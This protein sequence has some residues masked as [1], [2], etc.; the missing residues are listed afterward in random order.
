M[1]TLRTIASFLA[2]VALSLPAIAQDA[3]PEKHP[4][5]QFLAPAC[6]QIADQ[7]GNFPVQR[8]RLATQYY[9]PLFPPGR[10]GKL[11]PEDRKSCVN[12]EGACVVGDFLYDFNGTAIDRSTVPFKFGP[13]SGKGPFNTTNALDPCRTLAADGHV[14]PMGTVIFIPEMRNKICPQSGMPVDGCFIVA[15]VGSAITGGQR[16]DMFTGEC[17]QYDKRTSTCLDPAN[18]AFVAPKGTPFNVI[19][20]DDPLAAQLRK[21]TDAFINRGWQ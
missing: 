1:R 8:I 11:R 16:F 10:D 13:G 18:A 19:P 6:Q 5:G 14:Y 21:E 4:I 17:S 20:R 2:L 3:P 9:T 15:D 7:A 12:I